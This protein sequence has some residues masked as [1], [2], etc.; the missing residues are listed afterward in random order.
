MGHWWRS[1][2]PET[3]TSA[4]ESQAHLDDAFGLH[5]IGAIVSG[6]VGGKQKPTETL[7]NPPRG[8]LA[9]T[10]PSASTNSPGTQPFLHRV[11]TQ[12]HSRGQEE[13]R[14]PGPTCPGP[15]RSEPE[16]VR[17][18]RG[19]PG[20][21]EVPPLTSRL[22]GEDIPFPPRHSARALPHPLQPGSPPRGARMWEAAG[23][24]GLAHNEPQP[25]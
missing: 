23:G 7:R 16:R 15:G 20:A 18:P 25:S 13:V 4:Q 6:S 9:S 21:P 17:L 8:R 22:Q 12:P 24:G 14:A 3:G 5:P 19:G 2:F 11:R 10:T 1:S